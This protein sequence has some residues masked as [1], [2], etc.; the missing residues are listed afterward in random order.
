MPRLSIIIP[1]VD[2]AAR[3]EDTLA[4][5]LQNRPAKSEILVC[6]N[7]AYDDPYFLRDEVRFI[8]A[9]ADAGAV[10]CLNHALT[11][12]Q[13]PIVH[14]LQPGIEALEGWTEPACIISMTRMW[15]PCHR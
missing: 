5:V 1:V 15:P 11:V 8:E 9:P 6:F 2:R 7:H 4:S 14:L 13:A 10:D 3:W 12:A